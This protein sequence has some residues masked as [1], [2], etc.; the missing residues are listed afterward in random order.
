MASQVRHL[1]KAMF[2]GINHQIEPVT[3]FKFVEDGGQVVPNGLLRNE[4][5]LSYL[6]VPSPFAKQCDDFKFALSQ[7]CDLNGL[8]IRLPFRR[9]HKLSHN[10]S[11]H[12]TVKPNLARMDFPDGFEKRTHDFHF[13][14]DSHGTEAYGTKV[15]FRIRQCGDN[16][17]TR[18]HSYPQQIG[19]KIQTDL[20][21][22]IKIEK[23][24][25][26]P[27]TRHIKS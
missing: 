6:F 14:H 11:H 5:P 27:Q 20:I 10:G 13:Q 21:A 15:K 23:D 18:R 2:V 26:R 7:A 1:R 8:G 25:V 22:E 16:N 3:D 17:V 9:L 19:E 12:R 4:Q 24:D